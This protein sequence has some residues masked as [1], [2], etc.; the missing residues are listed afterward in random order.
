MTICTSLQMSILCGAVAPGDHMFKIITELSDPLLDWL[1]DDPVRPD[2]PREFRVSANRF[3]AALIDAQPQAMVCVSLAH[4]V[5]ATVADLASDQPDPTTA[6]FY[7][8]WSYVAG[9]AGQLLFD[10][11]A[12]IRQRF[13]TVHRFVTLSPKTEM[14]HRFHTRNGAVVLRENL[15][16]I[17]YE[18]V[19]RPDQHG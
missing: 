5:P 12:E 14:A 16:T 11:V 9:S 8:I 18:Y 4:G 13:P 3:V 19:I 15:H 10:T 1:R 6:V 7:T 2:I 17:N